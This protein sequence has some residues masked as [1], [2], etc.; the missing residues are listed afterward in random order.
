MAVFEGLAEGFQGLA[1]EFGELVQEEHAAVGQANLAGPGRGAAADHA[2]VGDGVVRGAEGALDDQARSIA[3]LASD[4][5]D[6]GDLDGFVEGHGR[7]DRGQ[8][9]GQQGLAG[10]GRSDHEHVVG[11]GSGDFEG[12]LGVLVAADIGEIDRIAGG[13]RGHFGD[14]QGFDADQAH[15]VG[16]ELLQGLDR[17][18]GDALHDGGF[19][20]VYRRDEG[21][22]DAGVAGGGHHRQDAVGVADAAVQRQ[23]TEIDGLTVV[24]SLELAG[25]RQR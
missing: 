21:L 1:A 4:A 25:R 3:Q 23:L 7:E 20:A 10:A 22:V 11:A 14:G 24:E 6:L 12:A 15:V 2:G 16:N 18:D 9:A 8:R 13:L 19:G 5:V 17:V